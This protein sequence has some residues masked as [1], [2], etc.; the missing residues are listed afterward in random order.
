MS[1]KASLL[2]T[3]R[4]RGVL[5]LVLYT[6]QAA[7]FI[8]NIV[9]LRRLPFDTA[10]AYGGWLFRQIGPLLRSD[11]IARRNLKSVFPNWDQA[12]IDQTVKG[13][14]DNLGRGAAEFAHLDKLDPLDPNG[15]VDVVGLEHLKQAKA[16]GSFVIVSAHM[17]NW[18]IASVAAAHAGTPLNNIYRVSDNPWVDA[19]LRKYRSKF[20]NRMI[21]KGTAGSREAFAGLKR[22]EPLA[23]LFDQKLNEGKPVPFFGRDAMTA[24]APIEMAIKLGIP[25]LPTRLERIDK[26]K[27]KVTVLPPMALPATGNREADAI[28]ILTDLHKMLETWIL[29][30]PE[31][32]FWVHKRWPNS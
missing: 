32:W 13:V 9:V 12:K 19:Y 3:A 5:R 1:L 23:L 26:T 22:G 16:Q 18:E 29:E 25:I 7:F 11:R 6:L 15:R 30:R 28:A 14:W 8:G 21:P 10:S 2:D 24:T 27:F 20:S 31:Q 4:R 17:A